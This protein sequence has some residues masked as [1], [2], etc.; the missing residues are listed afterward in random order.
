[1]TY[2]DESQA[3]PPDRAIC[4]PS[5]DRAF[6][7]LVD[8]WLRDR[9]VRTPVELELALRPLFP[10][11]KVQPRQLSGERGVTWYVY[12]DGRFHARA[13]VEWWD[14]P[15]AG[16]ATLHPDTG[17]VLEANQCLAG[18]LATTTEDIIGRAY[19]DF[20]PPDAQAVAAALFE[21]TTGIPLVETVARVL[22]AD[23]STL[24]VELRGRRVEDGID[25]R[26]RAV[27][28]VTAA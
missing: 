19:L 26:I 14:G 28:V 6:T 15:D 12:R 2:G 17:E 1:M 23:A 25:L 13:D 10:F 27:S 11:T 16:I 20:V 18:L 9:G 3:R 8:L 4:L 22:R 7:R 21:A 24:D 5:S